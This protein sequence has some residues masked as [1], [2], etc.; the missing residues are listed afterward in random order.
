MA[1]ARNNTQFLCLAVALLVTLA[2][3]TSN[4]KD[5]DPDTY[6]ESMSECKR[7]MDDYGMRNCRTE[8]CARNNTETDTYCQ[9]MWECNRPVHDYDQRKCRNFCVSMGY[10]YLRS[11]CEHH[12]YPYCCCHK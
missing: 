1:H 2:S 10:D 3:L 11:Y 4:A 12:P 5:T 9:T 7:P 8:Y 6:C